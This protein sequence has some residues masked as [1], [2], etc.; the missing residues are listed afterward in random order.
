MK[1]AIIMTLFKGGFIYTMGDAEAKVGS[2]LSTEAI[3]T[4]CRESKF[5]ALVYMFHCLLFWYDECAVTVHLLIEVLE[6][7][8]TSSI[9]ESISEKE[10]GKMSLLICIF[11]AICM[12]EPQRIFQTCGCTYSK[13][14]KQLKK[15]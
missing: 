11:S 1:R 3:R 4:R 12:K 9:S 15:E 5:L 6:A 7:A 13:E 8:H 14:I 2:L 10:S